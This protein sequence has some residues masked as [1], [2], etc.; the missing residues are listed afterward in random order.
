MSDN[1]ANDVWFRDGLRFACTRCGNCCTGEPGYVWVDDVEIERIAAALGLS[2][3][4]FEMR[5]V[6]QVGRRRS[7]IERPDGACVFFDR[8]AG[9][10]IYPHRP[11]QCRSWPFW[12]S[13]VE[14]VESWRRVCRTCPGAGSGKLYSVDEIVDQT[15][16]I[17]L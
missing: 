10:T 12:E 14:S 15:R 7:L 17:R 16:K 11:R 1:T 6:R 9:C 13:N 4:E 3:T 2:A 5:F 8:A